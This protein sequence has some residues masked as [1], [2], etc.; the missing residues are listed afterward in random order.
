M[1]LAA[2]LNAPLTEEVHPN[3]PEVTGRRTANLFQAP[4]VSSADTGPG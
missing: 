2:L 3:T 4:V 1:D